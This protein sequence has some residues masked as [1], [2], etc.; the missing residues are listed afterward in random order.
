MSGTEHQVRELLADPR[1]AGWF[2]QEPTFDELQQALRAFG[3]PRFA[4]RR[5]RTYCRVRSEFFGREVRGVVDG[6]D[7][8]G[9]GLAC[10]RGLLEMVD[11]MTRRGF[12][13][14]DEFRLAG[15]ACDPELG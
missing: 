8:S 7:P 13:Q 14:I 2:S 12:E 1:L 4:M 10:L 11:E 9:A 3:A 5:G 15:A 6:A